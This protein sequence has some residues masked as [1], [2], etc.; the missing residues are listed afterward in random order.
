MCSA[1]QI[2]QAGL[3]VAAQEPPPRHANIGRWP[4]VQ[5]DSERTKA[6]RKERALLIAQ[7]ATLVRL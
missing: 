6:Q 2:R 3:T 1:E 7:S 4:V 5:D